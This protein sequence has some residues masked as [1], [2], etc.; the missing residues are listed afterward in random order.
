MVDDDDNDDGDIFSIVND[1]KENNS[2]MDMLETATKAIQIL[3][4]RWTLRRQKKLNK[5]QYDIKP[6]CVCLAVLV[7]SLMSH[8]VYLHWSVSAASSQPA[9][10]ISSITVS[11]PGYQ[12]T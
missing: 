3:R 1:T 10:S 4:A 12:C 6:V 9:S 7:L 2:L 5:K 8:A 11:K